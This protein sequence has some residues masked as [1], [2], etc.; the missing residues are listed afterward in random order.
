MFSQIPDIW[1]IA[2]YII[3]CL[4]AVLMFLYNNRRIVQ[5]QNC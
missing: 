5:E 1:S 3:I 4:M 2:G